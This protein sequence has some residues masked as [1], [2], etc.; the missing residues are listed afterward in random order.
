M[1]GSPS[2]SAILLKEKKSIAMRSISL[3]WRNRLT[4][5][6]KISESMLN[7]VSKK[8]KSSSENSVHP[9]Q[10]KTLNTEFQQTGA[11]IIISKLI[12]I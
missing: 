11:N 1:E 12:S 5:I 8:N 3:T 7:K 2:R 10:N 6:N 9:K 4:S